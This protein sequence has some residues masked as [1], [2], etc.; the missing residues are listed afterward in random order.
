MTDLEAYPPAELFIGFV[1]NKARQN[2][3]EKA[4][5]IVDNFQELIDHLK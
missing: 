3:I 1:G 4:P 2:V 5:W